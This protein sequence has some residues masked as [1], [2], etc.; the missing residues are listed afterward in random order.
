VRIDFDARHEGAYT[1]ATL[2]RYAQ[3]VCDAFDRPDGSGWSV[4]IGNLRAHLRR[5]PAVQPKVPPSRWAG[6]EATVAMRVEER[7]ND[8]GTLDEVLLF[9]G[10]RCVFHLEQMDKNAWYFG[11]YPDGSLQEQYDIRARRGVKV[12]VHNYQDPTR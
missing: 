8:D 9:D 6:E 5:M 3:A 1:D 11:L 12:K 7:R 4:A 10:E 2:G